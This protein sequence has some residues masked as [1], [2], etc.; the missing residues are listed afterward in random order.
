MT[1]KEL[2]SGHPQVARSHY[3][4]SQYISRSRFVGLQAQLELCMESD[5]HDTV[6]EIG[7]GPALLPTL[8]RHFEYTVC[9]VDF[10]FDLHPDVLGCLPELPFDD[11]TFDTV[12]AFEILEHMPFSMLEI[13]LGELKRIARKKYSFPSPASKKYSHSQA[14]CKSFNWQKGISK[15]SMA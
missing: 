15:S 14:S 2:W 1:N 12:C 6:L 5:K 11:F 13:C 4:S 3:F 9:T 10:A 7:I 8:L